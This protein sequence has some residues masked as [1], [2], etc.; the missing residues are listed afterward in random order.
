ME[1]VEVFKT[2]VEDPGLADLLISHIHQTLPDYQANFD[3]EDCDKI[4]RIAGGN[5]TAV[6]VAALVN[7]HGFECLMLE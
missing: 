4:L 7:A 5:F 1:M 6:K 3:L 2:N